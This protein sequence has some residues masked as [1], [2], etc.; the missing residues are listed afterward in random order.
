MAL[1]MS[2]LNPDTFTLFLK[3]DPFTS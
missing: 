3:I 2:F 1:G